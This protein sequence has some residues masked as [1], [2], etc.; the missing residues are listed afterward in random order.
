MKGTHNVLVMMD[1]LCIP[2]DDPEFTGA[3][4]DYYNKRKHRQSTE[5]Y[6]VNALRELGHTV[7]ILGVD[8]KIAPVV[9]RL[10][11]KRPDIVFNLTEDFRDDRRMDMHV[12]ALLEMFNVPFTGTGSAGLMLC[13]NK[14][15]CK[16]ILGSHKIGVPSF[17][18][19]SPETAGRIPKSLPYPL[20]V[21]PL[22]EDGSDG[23]SNAS[24][25]KNADELQ[26][27]L[28]LV[29]Q[30]YNQPAIAEQYIQGRELYITVLGNRRLKVL[31]ARE[32]SFNHNGNGGPALATQHV[33]W[34]EKYQKKWQV[35]FGFA[36][37]DDALAG[38]IA[39]ICKKTY[40]M[41]QI[42]DYGR[43]D[44][45]LT[46]DERVFIIEANPNPGLACGDEVAESF[47]RAGMDYVEF[48][49]HLLRV[50]L[51]RH[52]STN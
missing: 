20:V 24:L 11:E 30:T 13:R 14:G 27:R 23:I 50:A 32:L 15:L 6:V 36:E 3:P 19:V 1:A 42:Q 40:R 34:N 10:T 17:I 28:R 43:I 37:L 47:A 12:A 29:H 16:Q 35:K 52:T 38:Q 44:L 26:E 8:G 33:K 9:Q 25:V 4:P 7:S 2:G 39:H 41:L 21:K 51:R 5:H 48:I 45:R 22:Y 49:N 18:V 31:P 46:P